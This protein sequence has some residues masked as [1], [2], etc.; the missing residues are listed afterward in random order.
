MDGLSEMGHREDALEGAHM[1]YTGP[2]SKVTSAFALSQ[3]QLPTSLV[4]SPL[5]APLPGRAQV[6]KS[7]GGPDPLSVRPRLALPWA[8]CSPQPA[9]TG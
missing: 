9:G 7:W 2:V 6:A 8:P 4:T 1:Y 3:R 5:Q